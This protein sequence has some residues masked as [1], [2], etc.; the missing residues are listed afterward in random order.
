MEVAGSAPSAGRGA[1]PPVEGAVRQPSIGPVAARH[2][3]LLRELRLN[4]GDR[5]TL[6][7]ATARP[8]DPLVLL[9]GC[10]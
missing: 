10:R 5:A 1:D 9:V 4:P 7:V 2:P 6:S 8:G 3:P